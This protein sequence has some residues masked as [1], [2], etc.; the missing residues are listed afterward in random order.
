M[1]ANLAVNPIKRLAYAFVGLLA[2]NTILLLFLLQNAI[3]IRA[4]L[5]ASHMG[6]PALEIPLALQMSVL[7]ASF[8]LAG[9]LLVGLPTA[10][11]V[12]VRSI[13]RLPWPVRLLVG[14]ALG[15]FALLV[16]FVLLGHGHIGFPASFTGT[17]M[18][19][20]YAILVFAVSFAVYVA[21]LCR[22]KVIE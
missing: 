21:L 16:I 11:F 8:S 20:A 7:Y 15:P 3:R 2:G 14:A 17:R 18:L 12:P 9:W 1:N 4:L 13:M 19:R 6:K 10:L 5:L 22:E